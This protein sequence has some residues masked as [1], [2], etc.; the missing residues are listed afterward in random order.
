MNVDPLVDPLTP[1]KGSLDQ[2]YC[3]IPKLIVR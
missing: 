2:Q 1:S 3:N